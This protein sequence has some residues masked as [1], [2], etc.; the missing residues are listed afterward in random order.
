[1]FYVEHFSN[2]YMGINGLQTAARRIGHFFFAK[3]IRLRSK[4][5]PIPIYS[6]MRGS[7]PWSRCIS[8]DHMAYLFRR[9]D[10]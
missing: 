8:P 3:G 10:L 7:L 1:M 2:F 4:K 6:V 5:A 9:T